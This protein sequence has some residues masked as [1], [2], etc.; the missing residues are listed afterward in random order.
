MSSDALVAPVTARIFLRGHNA[1][2]ATADTLGRTLSEHGVAR[3]ILGGFRQ[4]SASALQAVDRE[5]GTVADGL[6]DLDLG[7]VLVLGW[8]KYSA[9]T[10]SAK[11][12]LAAPGS[13]EVLALA[14]HR[15]TSTYRPHVDVYVDGVKV[16]SLEFELT[17]VFALTGLFA[18]VSLGDL[19]ALRGGDCVVTATLTLEGAQLAQRQ[20][21]L[22]LASAVRLQPPIPLVNKVAAA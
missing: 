12:T 13:E 18:V 21:H 22:E 15:I 20:G 14:T 2:A 1:G 6:L 17:M 9:L 3:S 4:L 10:E 16:N 19:V 11:R 5:I 8:R 7:D